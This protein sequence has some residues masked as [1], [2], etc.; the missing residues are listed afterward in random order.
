MHPC[1]IGKSEWYG[2]GGGD[3]VAMF[4]GMEGVFL[5]CYAVIL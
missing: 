4:A 5:Y 2:W 1:P 3:G